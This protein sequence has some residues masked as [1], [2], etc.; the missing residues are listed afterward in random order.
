MGMVLVELCSVIVVKVSQ[1]AAGNCKTQSYNIEDH[2]N[3]IAP[4]DTESNL[5]VIEEHRLI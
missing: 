5:K 3:L 4:K 2:I 1:N